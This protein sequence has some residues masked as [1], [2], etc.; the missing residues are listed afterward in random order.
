MSS[1]IRGFR[2]TSPEGWVI[3]VSDFETVKRKGRLKLETAHRI[4]EVLLSGVSVADHAAE[5]DQQTRADEADECLPDPA[6]QRRSEDRCQDEVENKRPHNAENDINHQTMIAIHEL[7]REPPREC[8][9]N[10]RSD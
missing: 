3:T 5:R 10:N 6:S 4:T 9:D 7:F 8:T 2:R 1:Q